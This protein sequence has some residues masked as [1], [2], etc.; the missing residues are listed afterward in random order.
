MLASLRNLKELYFDVYLNFDNLEGLV[1]SGA[2]EVT[3]LQLTGYLV[4]STHPS[5]R[6]SQAIS[7][8]QG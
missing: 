7:F 8:P 4:S 6:H 2:A 5:V 3:K 1:L